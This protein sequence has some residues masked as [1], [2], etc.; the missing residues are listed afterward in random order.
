MITFQENTHFSQALPCTREEFW[1]QV[2]KLTTRWRIDMRR[3]ILAA[4][5]ASKTQGAVALHNL[6]Q[7]S[8]YQKFLIKKQGLKKKAGKTTRKSF[9]PLP[10]RSRTICLPLS[11]VVG[12]LTRRKLLKAECSG[13][14]DWRIV[15]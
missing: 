13:I 5:E 8:E 15:I 3:A 4:V 7:N 9:W 12:S 11:S 2:K 14:A 1:E 10:R 6:L